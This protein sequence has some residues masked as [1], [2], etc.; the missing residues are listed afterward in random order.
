MLLIMSERILKLKSPELRSEYTHALLKSV[1][2]SLDDFRDSYGD[3]ISYEELDDIINKVSNETDRDLLRELA[4]ENFID[5]TEIE[6]LSEG[7]DYGQSSGDFPEYKEVLSKIC[8]LGDDCWTSYDR[9]V[10]DSIAELFS[11]VLNSSLSIA[12]G[13]AIVD[14]E[15]SFGEEGNLT[16][17]VAL[18]VLKTCVPCR[19]NS[20]YQN[21]LYRIESEWS[22][23]GILNGK[24]MNEY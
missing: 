18:F 21:S 12:I 7:L 17:R 8:I 6:N 22:E 9:F 3:N 19:E 5:S 24:E 20:K 23:H 14:H 11:D 1:E 2:D 16:P 4:F 13:T 10:H 15:E